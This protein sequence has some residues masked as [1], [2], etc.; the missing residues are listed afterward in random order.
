MNYLRKAFS[1][2]GGIFLAALV[3]AALAPK[4]ARGI[5]AALVQ[6]VP[7]STT[8]L[9]QNES[10]LVSLFCS[11]DST[12]CVRVDLPGTSFPAFV[13][14]SGYTFIVTDWEWAR[15]GAE[16]GALSA[17]GLSTPNASLA[18]SDALADK[19]GVCYAH[20]HYE[21]GIKF[22][23]GQTIID[24]VASGGAGASHVQGYL[25]PN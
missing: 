10:Q 3:I 20:E 5:A 8:H 4:A 9:G 16:P 2:L 23:S 13:V 14:P 21:T 1:T 18:E 25:V 7:G 24:Q 19:L 17:N 11:V 22:G 12:P 6:I 15:G